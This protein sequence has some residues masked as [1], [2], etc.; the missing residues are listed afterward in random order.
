MMIDDRENYV[1]SCYIKICSLGFIKMRFNKVKENPIIF[2]MFF[3]NFNFGA[4]MQYN[5][6]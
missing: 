3:A 4:A 5:L 1:P 2:S 6:L